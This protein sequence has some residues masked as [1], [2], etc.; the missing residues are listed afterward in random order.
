MRYINLHLTF[1]SWTAALNLMK[2]CV[3]VCLNN[4]YNPIEF[5]GHRSKVKVS[6][7]L[8]AFSVCMLL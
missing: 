4:L 8:C 5:Q 7:V 6:Y 1:D 3:N 2:F